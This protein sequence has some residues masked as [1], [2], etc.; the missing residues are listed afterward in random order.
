MPVHSGDENLGR[1]DEAYSEP[2]VVDGLDGVRD[3]DD[4][5]PDRAFR[6]AVRL[7][8]KPTILE[9]RRFRLDVGLVQ[10]LSVGMVVVY[11]HEG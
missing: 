9:L 6:N 4:I 1:V 2:G 10:R 11:D 7:C 3:L 8:L 5:R